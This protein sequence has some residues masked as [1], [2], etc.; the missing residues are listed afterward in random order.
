MTKLAAPLVGLTQGVANFCRAGGLSTCRATLRAL[1]SAP[2]ILSKADSCELPV[3]HPPPRMLLQITT[4]R[5][6]V[7]R[8]RRPHAAYRSRTPTVKWTH[9]PAAVYTRRPTYVH[10]DRLHRRTDWRHG[11]PSDVCHSFVH[12]FCARPPHAHG[13]AGTSPTDTALPGMAI[14]LLLAPVRTTASGV[15]RSTR[16]SNARP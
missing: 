14:A 3:D 6:T 15:S 16:S 4:R 1:H 2:R 12:A 13:V 7:R 9:R 11:G 10:L 8:T 5:P